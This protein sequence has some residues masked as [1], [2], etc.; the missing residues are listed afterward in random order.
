MTELTFLTSAP[1][2]ETPNPIQENLRACLALKETRVEENK[3][4]VVPVLLENMPELAREFDIVFEAA[5]HNAPEVKNGVR[6]VDWTTNQP[7]IFLS[8]KTRKSDNRTEV[9][10]REL[11]KKGPI[12]LHSAFEGWTPSPGSLA[13]GRG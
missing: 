3:K 8:I 1:V 4:I 7:N 10:S 6:T 13:T 5:R 11:I 9:I 12:N 2:T